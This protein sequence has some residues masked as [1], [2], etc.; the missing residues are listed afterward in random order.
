VSGQ[1]DR[2]HVPPG[3][4]QELREVG[5]PFF[6]QGAYGNGRD[7]RAWETHF[8][9]EP[10]FGEGGKRRV[11]AARGRL[12]SESSGATLYQA[13][14]DGRMRE[15]GREASLRRRAKPSG[16][17]SQSP[18]LYDDRDHLLVKSHHEK[19]PTA[20][21]EPV[22]RPLPSDYRKEGGVL[23]RTGS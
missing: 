6:R 16:W 13:G 8:M 5:I 2:D 23:I 22:S 18:I 12:N 19:M 10:R 20:D 14:E 17:P 3:A 15:V 4:R 11:R 21:G 9:G 7:R 1:R